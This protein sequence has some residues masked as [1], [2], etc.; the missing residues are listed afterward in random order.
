MA[1]FRNI[2]IGLRLSLL[3]LLALLA[4][5][6]VTLISMIL[7]SKLATQN[8][9]ISSIES[10]KYHHAR[11]LSA[12]RGHQLFVL[13]TELK[14]YHSHY[15]RLQLDLGALANAVPNSVTQTL[16]TLQSNM[17]L[18]H[19]YNEERAVLSEKKDFMDFDEWYD[20]QERARMSIVL[21]ATKQ[22]NSDI[23][24]AIDLI[25]EAILTQS[26]KE[27]GFLHMLQWISIAIVALIITL[28][29]QL[30]AR[31][32]IHST[33]RMHDQITVMSESRNLSVD[34]CIEGKDELSEVA[35]YLSQLMG[36][37]R[38]T[39][40]SAKQATQTNGQL[41]GELTQTM[42]HLAEQAQTSAA[43]AQST[44]SK[45]RIIL[46]LVQETKEGSQS[47]SAQVMEVSH[48]LSEA[49]TTLS[50]MSH[51]VESSLQAQH[52]LSNTLT[53]LS[54][55]ADQTK[56]VLAVIHDIADQT[57]LLALNAA[58][59]AARA[60]EHGRG[61]AV[62]A[63][64]VRKLAENT[65]KSLV[66]IQA[67]INVITQS[68]MDVASQIEENNQTIKKLSD[69][70]QEVDIRM[71]TS[72]ETM[73]RSTTVSKNQVE[74][75][76][77]VAH[78]IDELSHTIDDLDSIAQENSTQIKNATNFASEIQSSMEDLEGKIN[79]FKTD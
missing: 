27:I 79:Q 31:S 2:T 4:I 75:M 49:R 17:Q 47:T 3:T 73:Q 64:E 28:I 30:I 71:K 51:L 11:M 43:H 66:E 18:W 34:L 48:T 72:V 16:Q 57:N 39:L 29:A 14:R 38:A 33:K 35:R 32:I 56:A 67:S 46:D 9:Y 78:H 68:I 69:A 6:F 53:T 60:G 12:I 58:I 62:V 10:F 59:E 36:S 55:D 74:K 37:I 70:S 50:N 5:A 44:K 61:F 8:E 20:S 22:L 65:Q 45:N 7:Q 76:L 21:T 54:Q 1:L 24:S 25:E 15:D 23:D 26:S 77:Q 40:S 52:E 41:I 42:N 63:D 19:T 13:D